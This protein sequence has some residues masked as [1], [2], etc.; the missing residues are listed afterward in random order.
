MLDTFHNTGEV[1]TALLAYREIAVVFF[2][3]P[4]VRGEPFSSGPS[5]TPRGWNWYM[6]GFMYTVDRLGHGGPGS[7]PRWVTLS[8]IQFVP[9]S[10]VLEM[11][12]HQP[13][14]RQSISLSCPRFSVVP[15]FLL[16]P[17]LPL[18]LTL[19]LV[20]EKPP[21]ANKHPILYLLLG[22]IW[23]LLFVPE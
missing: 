10:L 19:C 18:G 14:L 21:P 15:L 3:S 16:R 11:Q 6:V 7:V 12:T 9:S 2:W 1:S 13:L 5:A 4:L 17:F 8:R 20:I 23:S 22:G